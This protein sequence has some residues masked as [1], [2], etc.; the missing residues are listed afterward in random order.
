MLKLITYPN[1]ILDKV[2]EPVTEFNEELIHVVEEM[3]GVMKKEGGIGLAAPQVGISK[4]I[5]VIEIDG[6]QMAFI[7]PEII[8][9]KDRYHSEEIFTSEGCLSFPGILI[10]IPRKRVISFKAQHTT[11]KE[12]GFTFAGLVSVC[13]QHELDHLNGINF[14]NYLSKDV[15]NFIKRKLE[16]EKS[17][18][19]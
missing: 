10:T 19:K 3:Y 4:R 6:V 5:F 9:H 8:E 2:A 13:F 15:Q 7:N 12:F 1:P 11:G 17:N 14:I 18:V 16:R